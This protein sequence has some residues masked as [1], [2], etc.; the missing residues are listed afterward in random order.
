MPT[1]VE[2]EAGTGTDLQ[3]EFDLDDERIPQSSRARVDRIRGLLADLESRARESGLS[4]ELA[5]L[6]RIR[7]THLPKLLQSY[8]DIPP[9]HRSEVFRE[10]GRSASYLLN[11]RLDKMTARMGEISAMLARGHLNAF[12]ENMRF[13][14]LRYGSP[15]SP[16]D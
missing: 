16:F 9:E 6:E 11:E 12:A 5:E 14:D 15:D 1:P 13:F 4:I 7:T 8:I 2:D 10:T 3:A